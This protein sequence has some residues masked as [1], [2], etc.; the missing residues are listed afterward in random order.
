MKATTYCLAF[1]NVVILCS[2]V[3][4]THQNELQSVNCSDDY[5]VTTYSFIKQAG[6]ST[7]IGNEKEVILS[8]ST[9]LMSTKLPI[10]NVIEILPSGVFTYYEDIVGTSRARIPL[11][12]IN[13]ISGSIE[14]RLNLTIVLR[15]LERELGITL[16]DLRLD[17]V[18]PLD[19]GNKLL[20]SITAPSLKHKLGFA[21]SMLYVTWQHG[22]CDIAYVLSGP[23]GRKRCYF[24]NDNLILQEV[25]NASELDVYSSAIEWIDALPNDSKFVE[26]DLKSDYAVPTAGPIAGLG[27]ESIY[28]Y[29]EK[30]NTIQ[31]IKL[32]DSQEQVIKRGLQLMRYKQGDFIYYGRKGAK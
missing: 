27:R 24:S 23:G 6:T 22:S 13:P 16:G 15:Q 28:I 30:N 10:W 32:G 5:V 31:E 14:E 19:H 21:W 26:F 25:T 8:S 20:M 9:V 4:A 2:C 1:V 7:E 12:E 18:Q 3:I 11:Q 17:S 29:N